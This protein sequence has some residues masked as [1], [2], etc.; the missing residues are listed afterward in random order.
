MTPLSK[1]SIVIFSLKC[2]LHKLNDVIGTE[3]EL[4][5]ELERF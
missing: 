2:M 5:L 4:E 3:L 1:Y